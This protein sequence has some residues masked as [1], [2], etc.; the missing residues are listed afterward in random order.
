[1]ASMSSFSS[2]VNES[3]SEEEFQLFKAQLKKVQ[4][5]IEEYNNKIVDKTLCADDLADMKSEMK[6]LT[7]LEQQ[8]T[9]EKMKSS[10]VS[11]KT[12]SLKMVQESYRI[13]SW[14]MEKQCSEMDNMFDIDTYVD[15]I[16]ESCADKEDPLS[17]INTLFNDAFKNIN[18]FN[19]SFYG[20]IKSEEPAETQV[21]TQTKKDYRKSQKRPLEEQ[22]VPDE[23][24]SETGD[25][26]LQIT[27]LRVKRCLKKAVFENQGDPVS[28]HEFAIDPFSL[29]YTIENLFHLASLAKDGV[30]E[31]ERILD[32]E[33]DEFS[34]IT[35]AKK[36]STN[37][38]PKTDDI[39]SSLFTMNYELWKY[40]I[41]KYKI[42]K[43][44]I[45]QDG[46]E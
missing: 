26:E 24:G 34:T 32:N 14:L 37:A 12:M 20:T 39:I 8:V 45:K 46:D 44:M 18:Y 28:F 17:H 25:N 21:L 38:K 11:Y 33:N 5:L 19:L 9:S 36:K 31:I 1:M 13:C 22:V 29:T 40:Y 15:K 2:S 3:C 41:R 42:T 16:I 4:D 10:Y 23:V 6:Y 35:L 30:I 7:E 27:L 43:R